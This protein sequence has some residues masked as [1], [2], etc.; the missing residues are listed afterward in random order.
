M[1]KITWKKNKT[2]HLNRTKKKKKKDDKVLHVL[3]IRLDSSFL[4]KLVQKRNDSHSPSLKRNSQY[5][6]SLPCLLHRACERQQWKAT[7][8]TG[9]WNQWFPAS[10][11]EHV[12]YLWPQTCLC[13]LSCEILHILISSV[14]EKGLMNKICFRDNSV[15]KTTP[16]KHWPTTTTPQIH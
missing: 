4:F 10:P 12:G 9:T 11:G 8:M 6:P 5:L 14:V 7:A 16:C 2:K 1:I 15:V 13:L 3:L